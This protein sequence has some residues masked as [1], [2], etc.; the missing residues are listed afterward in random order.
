VLREIMARYESD[1]LIDSLA[2]DAHEEGHVVEASARAV[3][4]ASDN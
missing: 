3:R 1:A 2:F 4:M